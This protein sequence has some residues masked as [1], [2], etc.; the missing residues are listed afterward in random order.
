MPMP[1]PRTDESESDFMSRC[2]SALADEFP[3]R[4]Q[5][6]AVCLRQ[7]RDKDEEDD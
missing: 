5:R 3:D 2:M 7:W 1:S 6:A 4:G